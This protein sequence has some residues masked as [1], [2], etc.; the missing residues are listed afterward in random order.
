MATN[1]DPYQ[2]LGI[3]KGASSEEIK[4]AYRRLAKQLHPDVNPGR[5]DIEQQFK[6]VS[7]AYHLLS[8]PGKR[9]RYDRGEID[10]DGAERVDRTF[11]RAY[12]GARRGA[13][14]G[15][16]ADPFGGFNA[17][18]IFA[19]LFGSAAGATRGHK[20]GQHRGSDVTHTITVPFIEA[21][22]GGRRR[23]TLPTGKS[24]DITIPP[25][26]D[27][28]TKL[29]LKGQG[30]TG[31]DG[32][33]G[34]AIV[35]IRVEAHPIFTRKDNDIHLDVPVT[36]SEAVLGATIRIPTLDGHVNLKVP[37]NSNTG[38][39]L[40][41][42]GKGVQDPKTRRDGDLY[43]KLKI[44]LPEQPDR[45]LVNFVERWARDHDYEVRGKTEFG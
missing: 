39:T 21:A 37:A 12:S 14:G 25:A 3:S 9:A 17:E 35:E 16:E 15:R 38:T 24:I 42:K 1:R 4:H 5:A 10:A 40:R 23:V 43:V 7:A 18:S 44:V 28:Q 32:V 6:E 20:T 13:S 2:V 22:K 26:T 8:D 19:D 34:D 27:D 29:R 36:L 33:P 31:L 30:R 11:H 45:D 41:L